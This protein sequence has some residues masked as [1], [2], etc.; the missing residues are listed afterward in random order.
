MDKKNIERPKKFNRNE[1]IKNNYKSLSIRVKPD[2]YNVVTNYC[3]ENNIDKTNF[4][5]AAI[6]EYIEQH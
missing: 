5:I 6:Q 4:I 2:F 3:I 1:Y